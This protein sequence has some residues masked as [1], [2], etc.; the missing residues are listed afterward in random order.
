MSKNLWFIAI[1]VLSTG[2]APSVDPALN[3]LAGPPE[4]SITNGLIDARLYLPDAKNGYYRGPRF[5][6]S[7]VVYSLKYKDHNYFG[8]WFEEYSPTL[9][10]AIMGP[11]DAFDAIGFTEAKAGEQFMKIGIGTLVKPDDKPWYF[12]TPYEIVDAGKWKVDAK[13][14]QVEFLHRHSFKDYAYEYT[15]T[16]RLEPGKPELTLLHTLKNT[17]TETLETNVYNHNFFVIDQQPT[18]PDF[19]IEFPFT[20]TGQVRNGADVAE[21][22]ENQIAYKRVLTKGETFLVAPMIGFSSNPADNHV[23]IENKK[24]GA[25]VTVSCDLPIT[26]LVYWSASTTVCPEPY[27]RIVVAPGESLSWKNTYVFYETAR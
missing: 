14:D 13:K 15:K 18:G 1:A 2:S 25:G 5:D 3:K 6:W 26:R 27:S 20:L 23:T 10:D 4:A 7:G 9:H 11:V 19:K 24:T 21:L 16:L 17:G 22:K 8:Q 12:A